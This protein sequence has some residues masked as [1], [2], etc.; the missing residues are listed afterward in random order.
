MNKF[1]N[2][3]FLFFLLIFF[4]ELLSF[5]IFKLN[6]LEISHIP[7]IYMSKDVVPNDEWWTEE[8]EWG[9]WH[10]INSSTLQKRSCFNVK[11]SSNGIGARDSSFKSNYKNDVIL[12]GDSFAEG[13]G[14]NY[15]NT[16][17]K[18]LRLFE[19]ICN[20]FFIRM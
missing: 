10:K 7:K 13:Y 19:T 14:V 3:L 16:S 8:N 15:E 2:F 11:Y 12:L 4:I 17:Q 18:Y 20:Y 1:K 6:L 5:F 9:S